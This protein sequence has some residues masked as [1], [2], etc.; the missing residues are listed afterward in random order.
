MNATTGSRRTIAFVRAT[1][2]T[3]CPIYN[4]NWKPLQ[5]S[6][7]YLSENDFYY[8][9]ILVT[10]DTLTALLPRHNHNISAVQHI[11]CGMPY[12]IACSFFYSNFN[13]DSTA[14][15]TKRELKSNTEYQELGFKRK[16]NVTMIGRS[17]GLCEWKHRY[18][19]VPSTW[20]TVLV[21]A[22]TR[23]EEEKNKWNKTKSLWSRN[24]S[25]YAK[26][27]A[28]RKRVNVLYVCTLYTATTNELT[29]AWEHR[30]SD[31]LYRLPLIFRIPSSPFSSSSNSR[32]WPRLKKL[33]RQRKRTV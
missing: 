11:E 31:I 5:L 19:C 33:H 17:T 4:S 20:L 24:Y 32:R 2:K 10:S 21:V 30:R 3:N 18:D 28:H 15:K 26:V 9:I 16:K 29:N 6:W 13:T 25:V 22:H 14:E 23:D 1:K 8:S 12:C 7:S 27:L